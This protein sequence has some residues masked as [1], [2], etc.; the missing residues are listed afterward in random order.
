LIAAEKG[1]ET[2]FKI[3]LEKGANVN[4]KCNKGRSAIHYAVNKVIINL[5][6]DKGFDI[7]AL[8]NEGRTPLS[9]A[10]ERNLPVY[11][12]LLLDQFGANP[13]L[14]DTNGKLPSEC[15]PPPKKRIDVVL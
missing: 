8:D 1:L 11:V 5:L 2:A 4:V 6:L 12:N 10:Y 3:L 15:I 9:V 13:N 14:R 7:N